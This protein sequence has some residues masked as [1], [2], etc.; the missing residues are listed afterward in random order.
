MDLE[1]QRLELGAG[2][3]HF[4][5]RLAAF[6]A[7]RPMARADGAARGQQQPEDEQVDQ[8]NRRHLTAECLP[9]RGSR[10]RQERLEPDRKLS[11]HEHVH[12]AQRGADR[13]H[14]GGAERAGRVAGQTAPHAQDVTR[15]PPSSTS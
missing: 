3:L 11:G 9:E 2:E 4:Q 8:E 7:A 15:P 14:A 5:L 12:A 13:A 6:E 1:P 10:N